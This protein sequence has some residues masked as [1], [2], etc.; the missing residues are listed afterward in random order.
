MFE[1]AVRLWDS[2]LNNDRMRQR[3]P[4]LLYSDDPWH[5]ASSTPDFYNG[6]I[7]HDTKTTWHIVIPYQRY[8]NDQVTSINHTTKV[9]SSEA[10]S[11]LTMRYIILVLDLRF[12]RVLRLQLPVVRVVL[13]AAPFVHA[14]MALMALVT[15]LL[16]LWVRQFLLGF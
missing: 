16:L 14:A 2:A 6:S 15:I 7:T 3:L 9:F 13:P 8:Q 11:G 10:Q 5:H 1:K 12:L 4:H